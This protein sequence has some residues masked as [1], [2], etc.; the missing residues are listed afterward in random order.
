MFMLISLVKKIRFLRGE[1]FIQQK[2]FKKGIRESFPWGNFPQCDSPRGKLARVN[3][4]RG[5]FPRE[6]SPDTILANSKFAII[7]SRFHAF[8]IFFCR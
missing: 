5:N 4:P 2:Q 8:K 7:P 1:T 6:S 3:F